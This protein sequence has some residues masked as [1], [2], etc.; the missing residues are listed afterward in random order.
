MLKRMTMGL[1]GAAAVAASV[2]LIRSQKEEQDHATEVVPPGESVPSE[3]HLD[4][5]R[6]LGI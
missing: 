6:E 1:L 3:I 5:L 2:L 4:K